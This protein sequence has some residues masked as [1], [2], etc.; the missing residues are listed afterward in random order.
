MKKEKEWLSLE[1]KV[2]IL[3]KVVADL[4][5]DKVLHEEQEITVEF[6][7]RKQNILIWL[8]LAFTVGNFVLS[9]LHFLQIV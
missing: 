4:L 9:V 6:D 5:L 8:T 2:E 3:W 7:T 1:D